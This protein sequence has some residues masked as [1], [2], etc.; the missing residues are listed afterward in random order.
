MIWGD[1]P[2]S[3]SCGGF[4]GGML[5]G[6][7]PAEAPT[8]V[9]VRVFPNV[10]SGGRPMAGMATAAKDLALYVQW[11]HWANMAEVYQAIALWFI[12]FV[13]AVLTVVIGMGVSTWRAELRKRRGER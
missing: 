10:V 7:G 8:A 11:A 13:H 4:F 12:A 6:P 1:P 9:D 2:A 3:I 5:V